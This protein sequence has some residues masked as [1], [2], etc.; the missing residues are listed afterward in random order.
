MGPSF[1]S[2]VLAA[3][4]VCAPGCNSSRQYAGRV[5]VA[6]T[7]LP[8]PGVE[9][10]GSWLY[11]GKFSPSLDGLFLRK[12]GSVTT[13]TDLEGRFELSLHGFNR[14]IAVFHYGYA[15]VD[16][17]VDDWPAHKDVLIKL[18]PEHIGDKHE[19]P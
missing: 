1:W 3:C 5:L 14:R 11:R 8:A 15:S 7:G 12:N 17:S 10:H 2:V 18:V 6:E 4:L 13:A 16:I 19:I 9:V